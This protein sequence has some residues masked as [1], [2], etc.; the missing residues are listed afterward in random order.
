[1]A[2]M[3]AIVI[4]PAAPGRLTIHEVE[5][6]QPA[7]SEALVRVAAISLNR[8]E[9]RGVQSAIPGAR[10]GWDFA[11]VV[12]RAAADGSSPKAGTRVVGTLPTGAW[13][14]L[15]AAPT[16]AIASLPDAVSF[17][18]AA[19]LPIAGLTALYAL[20][21]G[22]PL[23]GRN[24][25]VTGASGGVGLFACQLARRGGARVVGVVRTA[26]Y[27]ADV[28]E[29][30]AHEVVVGDDCR[31]AEPFGPYH[32]ILESVGGPS[33]ASALRLLAADGV[34][35]LYGRSGAD[36]ATIDAAQF[37]LNGGST[38]YGFI[39]FHELKRRPASEGL[40][41]LARLVAAGE[42]RPH[43]AVEAPWTKIAEVAQELRER[44]FPGK[45]VL[46]VAAT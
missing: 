4:D 35:V 46:H 17:A 3:R 30:G 26:S 38:L 36:E 31:P 7:T 16:T 15:A 23:L 37:F 43:I 32:T 20:E 5:A 21:Q 40:A 45:A 29:A 12:E 42:V 14:E 18:Q 34:C 2:V 25:L 1:M 41:R 28:R 33:L 39:I 22:G 19:T 9:V 11:G 10:V 8:G 6:P 27:E 13:A 24:V 44:R